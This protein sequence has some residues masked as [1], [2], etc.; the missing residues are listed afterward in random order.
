LIRV[1]GRRPD[2]MREVRIEPN[3]L[4]HPEGSALVEFGKTRVICTAMVDNRVPPHIYGTG[5]GWLT[6]EYAMLPGSSAQRIQRDS[7]RGRPNGRSQEIQRLIGRS[8]RTVFDAD[9]FGQRTMTI[10]CDVIQADGGTRT[11]AVTGACVALG[12]ALKR[13]KKESKINV[14]LLR[15]CVAGVSVGVVEGVAALDLCYLEDAQAEVDMNVV[16]TGDGRFVEIQ[17]TAET[18]PFGGEKL[19]EM[20]DLARAGVARL[21]DLQREILGVD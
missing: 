18:A 3:Y 9:R 17:G 10:D 8:L 14:D 7:T 21:I 11:A 15:D 6:A 12:L 20:L 2:Q 1:D 4:L 19:N 13:L 16:L 5:K